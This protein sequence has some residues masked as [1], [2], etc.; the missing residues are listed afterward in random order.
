MKSLPLS[1]ALAATYFAAVATA[2]AQSAA[3]GRTLAGQRCQV[4]HGLDG[5]ATIPIAPNLAGE[6]AIYLQTQLKAFRSGK[7]EHEMMTVV[8]KDLTD[9]DIASVAA[10]YESIQ[11]TATMPD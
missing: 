4:C 10:W 8:A 9:A 3:D 5:I 7:R 11:V 1:V 2:H 6:S